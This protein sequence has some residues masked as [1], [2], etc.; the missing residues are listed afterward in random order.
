MS[1]N[2]DWC[3]ESQSLVAAVSVTAVMCCRHNCHILA[4]L[5]YLCLLAKILCFDSFRKA[6]YSLLFM[7]FQLFSCLFMYLFYSS[8]CRYW[9]RLSPAPPS[10]ILQ[11][12]PAP[13]FEQGNTMFFFCLSVN[14]LHICFCFTGKFT[15]NCR[16]LLPKAHF[17]LKMH[18]DEMHYSVPRKRSGHCGV[19]WGTGLRS[20]S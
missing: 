2:R 6:C 5:E 19:Q 20:C 7:Y 8:C 1:F 14:T 12:K 11:Q 10:P 3:T 18:Q 13:L 16:L 17:L 9:W 15:P 4:F